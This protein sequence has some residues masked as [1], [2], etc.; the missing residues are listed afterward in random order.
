MKNILVP[1]EDHRAIS[2]VQRTALLAAAK[3]G[4]RIEGVPLGPDFDALIAVNFAIPMIVADQKVRAD[5][6]LQLSQIFEDFARLR[7]QT[8][9][10]GVT[11]AWNGDDL[12]TDAKI[13]AYGRIF[14]LIV[15]GRPGLASDDPRGSTL[16][17]ALFD[18]GRPTLI[19]PPR[20][21]EVIGETIVV[22]WNASTETART[23]GF[24]MPFLKRARKVIVLSVSGAMSPGPS[25]DLL[26]R[27]L[28]RHGLAVTF[29]IID[30]PIASPG[31]TIL[32]RAAALGADLLIKGGYTQ[33][34]MRQM[35][36]GGATSQILAEAE[37]PVFMA[38]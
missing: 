36:F 38:H 1:I 23:I 35:I 5:L 27:S 34:R 6:S 13:G 20:P 28:E 37:I 22:S 17:A 19:A 16:E 7:P 9:E 26:A 18:S 32:S 3:F 24:A 11:L 8:G 21:P 4:S 12:M 31:R 30:N 10:D 29:E 33:S 2:S 25:P 15:I 14:D